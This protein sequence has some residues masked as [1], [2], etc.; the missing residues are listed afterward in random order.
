MLNYIF[1]ISARSIAKNK[2]YS[3]INFTGLVLGITVVLLILAYIR[4]ELN[5]DNFHTKSNRLYR[6][7]YIAPN[8]LKL[9]VTPPPIAPLMPEFFPG[10]EDAGR[11]YLRSVSVQIAEATTS[12]SWE[13]QNIAFADSSIMRMFTFET[14][15]GSMRKALQEPFTAIITDEMALKYFGTIDV[16]GQSLIFSGKHAFRI[17][18]VVKKFSNTSHIHFNMIVP[19]DNMFDL[20][21]DQAAQI[22]RQHFAINFAMSH[23]F[24]YVLLKEGA[25]PKEVDNRMEKFL[26]KYSHPMLLIG[27]KFELMPLLDIHMKST[28]MN[29]PSFPNSMK[30]IYV[31]IGVGLLTLIILCAN[32]INLATAQSFTRQKEIGIRK[33]LGANK[34]QMI[35]QF[36]AESFM[37]CLISFVL[38]LA[39]FYM[40]LP[41]FSKFMGQQFS[42]SQIVDSRLL[43]Y[44]FALI[45]IVALLAG[46]YPSYLAMRFDSVSAI[47][48]GRSSSHSGNYLRK[49]LVVAQLMIAAV[50]LPGSLMII[51]QMDYLEDC[52]LGF[53][54]SNIIT[55][56]IFSQNIN[57]I[58]GNLDENFRTRLNSYIEAIKSES[59]VEEA[60]F[61]SIP[62]GLGALYNQ[63]VPEGFPKESNLLIASIAVDHNFFK[64]YDIPLIAGR[65]FKD[66]SASNVYGEFIVNEAAVREYNWGSPEQALG[67]T[68]NKNGIDGRVIGVVK[69]FNFTSL[70]TPVSSLI[71]DF[72]PSKYNVLTVKVNAASLPENFNM[73]SKKW[74][75]IFPEKAFESNFL[76]QKLQM[77]YANFQNFGK[78][79]KAL[80]VI[81]IILACLGVYGL[82][83]FVIHKRVKEIGVRKVLG[84]S[85]ADVLKLIFKEFAFLMIVAFVLSGPISYYLIHQ[86]L[87]N[88]TYQTTIDFL[89]YMVSFVVL[90]LIIVL[91]IGYQAVKAS[92]ANPVLSLRSE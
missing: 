78:T 35:G 39:I 59:F 79:L 51:K 90:F 40:I 53:E 34:S 26:K 64:L 71:L 52:S 83:L 6:L 23:L 16:V 70:M 5:F 86:W 74:K 22:M 27:Q 66:E 36:L 28:L 1:K 75:E 14:L 33:I 85:V 45:V 43:M 54:K 21:D 69:D 47:R 61:S 58:F 91:T 2:V 37:F 55:I 30:I 72:D 42:F 80:T 50:L 92:L 17:S 56:S 46:A 67:K 81:A 65:S 8:D 31:F 20:E 15:S 63:I 68:L 29:E 76:D 57:H 41:S 87:Q 82:I 11:V 77:Q 73:L 62:P 89:I 25:N 84:A 3:I 24:T 13:E 38:S 12:E 9:A 7:T 19:F 60:S 18:A 32:Y 10:V 48:G 4:I 44:T 88:F 49:G